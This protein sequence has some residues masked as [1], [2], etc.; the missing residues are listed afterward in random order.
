[1]IYQAGDR[2]VTL[3]SGQNNPGDR[4]QRREADGWS[5]YKPNG[6][7]I[8]APVDIYQLPPGEYRLVSAGK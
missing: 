1:M 6:K 8:T 4:L 5:F 3:D 7:F 2:N